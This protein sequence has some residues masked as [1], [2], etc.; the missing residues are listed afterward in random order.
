MKREEKTKLTKEKI[1]SAGIK[2]FG[3]KGYAAA[4]INSVSDSGIAKGLIYHNFESKD[5]LYIECLKL[6]FKEFTEY[7]SCIGDET[8]YKIYFDK[9]LRFLNEKRETAAMVL[10]ALTN[11]P[12]NH[13]D[14]ISIMRR[15]YGKMNEDWIRILLKT[16]KL[17][18]NIDTDSALKYLS[19]MQDMFNWYCCNP[20]FEDRSF[21]SSVSLHEENLQKIFEYMLRGIVKEN[22]SYDIH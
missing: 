2:E 15:Q 17:R 16:N 8:D 21:E 7:L 5:E 14:E 9:R 6:C 13:L 19:V 18:D 22:D 20:K 12:G 4:S 3:S 10:E 1:I 11:P